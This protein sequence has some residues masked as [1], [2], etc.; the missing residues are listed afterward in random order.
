MCEYY[1]A[2][3]MACTL[4]IVSTTCF[5][6]IEHSTADRVVASVIDHPFIVSYFCV[7]SVDEKSTVT[8]M[9]YVKAV[10]LQKGDGRIYLRRKIQNLS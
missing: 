5:G 6:A 9:E 7:F 2:A 3:N 1:I 4:K 8:A 10:D